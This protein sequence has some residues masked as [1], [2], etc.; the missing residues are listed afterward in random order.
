MDLKQLIHDDD[1]VSPVIGVILMVAI[2]V[3]LAA[4]IASFVLGLG[5]AAGD[6]AP[7][8]SVECNTQSDFM[9]HTGGGAL[10]HDDLDAS[11]GSLNKS[12]G[13]NYTAGDVIIKDT[14]NEDTQ[15]IWNN[16]DGGSSSVIAEC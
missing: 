8:V 5:D 3:I 7:Q 6:S 10:E 2:T 12:A 11:T 13:A 15:L 9:N 16:P 14:V 1:A 4:V